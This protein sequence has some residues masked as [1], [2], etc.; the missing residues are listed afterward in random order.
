MLSG[1]EKVVQFRIGWRHEIDKPD[2]QTTGSYRLHLD[3]TRLR[4]KLQF[5]VGLPLPES[6]E[7]IRNH[8]APGGI[9]SEPDA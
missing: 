2:I 6:P 4:L 1:H 7:G 5:G 3:Q 8:A 9:L